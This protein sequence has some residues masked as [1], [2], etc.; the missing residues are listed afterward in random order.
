MVIRPPANIHLRY[1]PFNAS[2]RR[3]GYRMKP[4]SGLRGARVSVCFFS[5]IA[6]EA[7]SVR[8]LMIVSPVVSARRS[9]SLHVRSAVPLLAAHP[10]FSSLDA[11][12]LLGT[13][14]QLPDE[15]AALPAHVV[16]SV[17]GRRE[18]EYMS[19]ASDETATASSSK[20]TSI[21][22]MTS[23][24]LRCLVEPAGISSNF[25]IEHSTVAE[26]PLTS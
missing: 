24:R 10:V 8:D 7:E 26:K 20:P 12:T 19:A 23:P 16:G 6:S 17:A 5:I 3:S 9:M 14:A 13:S 2:E 25:T 22:P 21:S 4:R 15:P 11:T 1:P 18:T